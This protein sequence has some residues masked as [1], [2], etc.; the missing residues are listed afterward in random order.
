MRNVERRVSC[1][2]GRTKFFN[3]STPTVPE[4]E[5]TSSMCASSRA[6]CPA[7]AHNRSCLSYF[8]SLSDGP[9]S[10]G[11]VWSVITS[12]AMLSSIAR[13]KWCLWDEM[14][15]REWLQ[16]E[17][18]SV[19]TRSIC[20]RIRYV[21]RRSSPA[22]IRSDKSFL[23]STWYNRRRNSLN[24]IKPPPVPHHIIILFLAHAIIPPLTP[25]QSSVHGP[26]IQIYP[27]NISDHIWHLRETRIDFPTIIKAIRTPIFPLLIDTTTPD[28]TPLGYTKSSSKHFL[29]WI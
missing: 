7:A 20:Q 22:Y 1:W 29:Y 8:F 11:G 13:W 21:A 26:Q 2:P 4:P 17:E 10:I 6:C 24:Y 18:E 28:Q 15:V 5:F 12:V 3:V 27:H 14:R 25:S 19:I 9:C 23:I 16:L